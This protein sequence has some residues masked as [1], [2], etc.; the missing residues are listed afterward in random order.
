M[1]KHTAFTLI[2]LLVVI[3]IIAILAG[4]L[5]PALSQAREKAR[6]INCQSN[7]KQMG[8]ALK[9]YSH[10]WA[11]AFPEGTGLGGPD[12]VDA[13]GLNRLFVNDYLTTAKVYICPSTK[14]VAP[15]TPPPALNDYQV[16]Y[17]FNSDQSE[18]VCGTDSGLVIDDSKGTSSATA[19]AAPNHRNYGNVLFGDGHV[20]GFAGTGWFS[21]D[22]YHG[23]TDWAT[24]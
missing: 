4:M 8:I 1:K 21:I 10:D 14:D 5:L 13:T 6:R 3:A 19:T 9:L 7:L 2:E 24:Y 16:S 20:K 22:N 18:D 23:A 15:T 17:L 12:V 11:E